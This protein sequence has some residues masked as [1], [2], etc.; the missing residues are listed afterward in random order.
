MW[1]SNRSVGLSITPLAPKAAH[2]WPPKNSATPHKFGKC[3]LPNTSTFSME[4]C[5]FSTPPGTLR[6]PGGRTS[7]CLG[8]KSTRFGSSGI[9]SE[10]LLAS[11]LTTN[12]RLHSKKAP[13]HKTANR[14]VEHVRSRERPHVGHAHP[15]HPQQRHGVAAPPLEDEP[16]ACAHAMSLRPRDHS[17]PR[18]K[19]R[20][21][22]MQRGARWPA[23]KRW[24]PTTKGGSVRGWGTLQS[25]ARR[26]AR[27]KHLEPD[28]AS[29]GTD[30]ASRIRPGTRP[31]PS[32]QEAPAAPSPVSNC[33]ARNWTIIGDSVF[34]V[35]A[36]EPNL[37]ASNPPGPARLGLRSQHLIP[38]SHVEPAPFLVQFRPL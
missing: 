8:P 22:S 37:E 1:P 33:D 23:T 15:P 3:F 12:T 17:P 36:A 7:T 21:G 38:R 24:A 26:G 31:A 14:R 10:V 28:L 6:P 32:L 20:M 2:F 11:T 4:P 13:Q 16:L 9:S 25:D 35:R 18:A 29:Q 19:L 30:V 27:L 5:L 34:F